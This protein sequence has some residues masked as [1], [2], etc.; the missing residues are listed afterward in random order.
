MFITIIIY[1]DKEKFLT[2]FY[3]LIEEGLLSCA[4]DSDKLC[5]IHIMSMYIIIYNITI[6]H[7]ILLTYTQRDLSLCA[8]RKCLFIL[9]CWFKRHACVTVA[10]TRTECY[11]D[12]CFYF[13]KRHDRILEIVDVEDQ[14]D[15]GIV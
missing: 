8:N 3:N 5:N 2:I 11:D 1:Y 6:L 12:V 9:K 13:G 15:E 10:R 4:N 7:I 14:C